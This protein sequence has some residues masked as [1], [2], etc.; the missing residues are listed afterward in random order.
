MGC[1]QPAIATNPATSPDRLQLVGHIVVAP[2]ALGPGHV[3][4][5]A[6]GGPEEHQPAQA[7]RAAARA[8]C[9]AKRAAEGVAEQVERLVA[10]HRRRAGPTGRRD[11]QT[12]AEPAVAG[13]VDGATDGLAPAS[14][15]PK[16]PPEPP[17]LGEAVGQDERWAL[18]LGLD[19][20]GGH[21]R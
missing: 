8:A 19:A 3:V 14:W 5:D 17:G 16:R 10:G 7:G 18:A 4:L 9:R 15:S 2:A 1:G 11:R 13:Q 21:R 20:Q 12:S 6:G